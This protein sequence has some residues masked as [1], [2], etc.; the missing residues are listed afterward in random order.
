M[1]VGA[2]H[3]GSP[4]H[5]KA[6]FVPFT[7]P[8]SV[9]DPTRVFVAST[10]NFGAPLARPSEAPGAVL[11]LASNGSALAVPPAFAAAGGQAAALGGDVQLYTAQSPAFLNSVNNAASATKDLP[12]ASLPTGI[13]FNSGNGRPWLSNAPTGSAGDGTITVLD[14]NGVPLAG[15][16]DPVA[17][18]VFAGNATNR[19]AGT[20]HGLTAAA[21]GTAIFTKSPDGSGRA[22]FAA[23]LADGSVV[24]VHVE[25]GVD[26]LAPPGSFTPIPGVSQQAAESSEPRALTRVGIAFNWV[27]DRV[28]YVA[29]P[30]ANR[31]LALDID[32]D[33]SIFRAAAPRY[34]TSE[35][36]D[37][38]IDLVPSSV[39]AS[40]G[41]FSSNT[42]LGG[43]SDL[44]VLNRG[45]NTVVR[46]RQDGGV[47][48]ARSIAPEPE[49][50]GLR[51]AGLG[52]SPDGQTLWVSATAPGTQGFVL[53]MDAFGQGPVVRSMQ[54]NAAA[55]GHDLIQQGADFFSRP[56]EVAQLLGP[57]FNARSCNECHGVPSPGGM[58]AGP[59]SET[60]VARISGGT[61]D[62]LLGRGGPVARAH[63]IS[64]LGFP[65]SLPTGIPPEANAT[66]PRLAMTLRGTALID[67]ILLKDIVAAQAVQPAP[68]RGKLNRLADGRAGRFG[69]KAE[70]ATL[71][72]FLADAFR[73]EI[74]MTNPLVPDDFVSGCGS[75]LLR[76]ELDGV[77][78]QAVTAFMTTLD[79]PAPTAAC[80]GSAGAT[81][82][83]SIGCAQC[84]TPSLP[85][86]GKQA[87]LYS[88]L[89]LHDIGLGDG[90]PEASATGNE[91]RTMPLWRASDRVHFLHDGRASTIA[92]A[93]SA[94]GGQ[95]A[96]SAAAFQALSAADRQA[97]LDF[98]GCI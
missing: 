66:S 86:Q 60:R 51:A 94:H 21:L 76:P 68:V 81:R 19:S 67:D 5:D 18:G 31:I 49:I 71:V 1:Q 53:K 50:E 33:G 12:A 16:P 78:L 3:P 40:S 2:F 55:A 92:D 11:S 84:H 28:L 75:A 69:W 85:A 59:S 38:P 14:P 17:G 46:M 74:G 6:S 29:D 27:P 89:L 87:R 54:V 34:L 15:A 20:T 65:C 90:F 77:P 82:F 45:N 36:L 80:L 96:T 43:G 9:L 4:I 52:I 39:E 79:P 23:A 24:Q 62:P 88:D 25:K 91:F 7:A 32:D 93:I 64:E 37:V 48:E 41:N 83:A 22:V 47:I 35:A 8:G 73:T 98:I 61:F 44:F 56:L 58:G 13:S 95:A 97:L 63:S 42:T 30:L 10:S 70:F 26:G 72:E 57:L